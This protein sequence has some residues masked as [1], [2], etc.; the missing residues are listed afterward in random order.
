MHSLIIVEDNKT[1]G[2]I[3]PEKKVKICLFISSYL[4]GFPFPPPS[5]AHPSL[6]PFILYPP[7]KEMWIIMRKHYKGD[8]IGC[9]MYLDYEKSFYEI[10]AYNYENKLHKFCY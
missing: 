7:G 6:H 3:L 1:T 5:D 9:Q 4:I 10:K 8:K 2:S